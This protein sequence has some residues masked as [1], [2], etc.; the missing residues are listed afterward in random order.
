MGKHAYLI[1]AHSQF[2]LLKKLLRALDDPR[3]DIYVHVDA[4][5]RFDEQDLRSA[6]SRSELIFTDRIPVRWGGPSQI[7]SELILLKAATRHSQQPDKTTPP[8]DYYHLLSGSDLPLKPQDEIHSFFDAHAG[9]EFVAYWQLKPSTPARFYYAPFP[10]HGRN[11]AANLANNI[12]KGLH[13]I[14]PGDKDFQY[15]PNWFSITDSF[16]RYVLTQEDWIHKNLGHNCNCDEVFLQTVLRRSP[17]YENC[18]SSEPTTAG[19]S[20]MANLRFIDWTRGE[21]V[22]HPWTFT[23]ED[24]DLLKSRPELFARKFSEGSGIVDKICNEICQNTII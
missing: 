12:F 2:A 1:Q 14:F 21:S 19:N 13:R 15:G 5:S 3:N 9:K 4:R 17:F 10:E 20:G 6:V 22:R 7:W 8:Y 24:Y 11:F 16:A 23:D 18:Y